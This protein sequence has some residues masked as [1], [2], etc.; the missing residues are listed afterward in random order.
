MGVR[1]EFG[2]VEGV[3]VGGFPSLVLGDARRAL[4]ALGCGLGFGWREAVRVGDRA[5]VLAAVPASQR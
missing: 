3:P 2:G 5:V 1:C 4:P